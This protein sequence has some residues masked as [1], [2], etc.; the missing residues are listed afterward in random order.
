MSKTY[1]DERNLPTYLLRRALVC[2]PSSR[3]APPS[4]TPTTSRTTCPSRS[5]I[6]PSAATSA[7]APSRR[8]EAPLPSLHCSRT[9]THRGALALGRARAHTRARARTRASTHARTRARARTHSSETRVVGFLL[10][11]NDASTYTFP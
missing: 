3:T 8:G 6:S 7:S 1:S 11:Y 4:G 9:H 2:C 5:S 10:S